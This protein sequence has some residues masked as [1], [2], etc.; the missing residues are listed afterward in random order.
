MSS[1]T[2]GLR[3]CIASLLPTYT[4]MRHINTIAVFYL[5]KMYAV[6]VL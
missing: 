6:T 4:R 5:Y 2:A 3:T 1:A